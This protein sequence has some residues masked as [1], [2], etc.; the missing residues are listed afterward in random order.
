MNKDIT[1]AYLNRLK[2]IDKRIKYKLEEAERWRSIAE[3]HSSHL[4]E[5]KVQTSPKPDKMADAITNAVQYERDSYDLAARLVGIKHTVEEQIYNM[6]E[7]HYAVLSLYFLQNKS[8]KDMQTE[9][10]C[11]YNNV[12][13]G[14]R[15]AIKA[16]GEKYTEE[17][18][19]YETEVLGNT[20]FED[21]NTPNN[22]SPKED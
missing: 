22:P 21:E 11:S 15:R 9:L 17:I 16:F 18:K 4:S 10:D 6:E 13:G 5:D 8:Y 20:E 19:E 1:R 7:S 2:T 14:L 12:K 3:N